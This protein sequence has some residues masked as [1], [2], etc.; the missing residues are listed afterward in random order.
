MGGTTSGTGTSGTTSGTTT[1][2]TTSGTSTGT[3]TTTPG[4]TVYQQTSPATGDRDFDWGWL[5][6]LGLAGLAG[7]ARK[8]EEPVRYR[9]P[10]T[11]SR[12]GTRY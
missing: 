5:G 1:E 3:T 4:T 11:A 12:T 8:N 9:D 6:L 7:L 10:D 2:S